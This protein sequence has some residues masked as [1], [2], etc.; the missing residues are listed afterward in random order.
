MPTPEQIAA[1]QADVAAQ[2]AGGK[3]IKMNHDNTV[4]ILDGSRNVMIKFSTSWCGH[5]V[6]M[7]PDWQRLASLIH[8]DYKGCLVVS[9]DCEA[10]ADLCQAFGVQVRDGGVGNQLAVPC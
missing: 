10:S 8:K 5:C 4:A 3:A 7:E 2:L 9:V 1:A 6:K